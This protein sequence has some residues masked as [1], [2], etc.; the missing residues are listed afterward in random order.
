MACEGSLAC[1]VWADDRDGEKDVYANASVDGGAHWLPD[2]VRVDTDAPGAADSTQPRVALAAGRAFIVWE[3]DRHATPSVYFSRSEDG[4]ASW[5][6]VDQ[7]LDANAPG[8]S[9]SLAPD[10]AV[11]LSHV[12][13]VWADDRDGAFDVLLRTSADTGVTWREHEIRMD[14][15]EAGA[16]ACLFP[17]VAAVGAETR[18]VWADQRHGP[19]D[20]YANRAVATGP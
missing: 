4:G 9:S 16:A 10:L 6:L 17:R 3:D 13:V 11:T 20:I 8:R 5:S 15:D 14:T 18:V 12:H 2:D 19:G 7:R 1:V